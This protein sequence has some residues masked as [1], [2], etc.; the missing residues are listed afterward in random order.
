[1]TGCGT[2]TRTTLKR[3]SRAAAK[4]ASARLRDAGAV[5]TSP[6]VS[7]R[8]SVCQGCE[9]RKVYGGQAYCGKP[10]LRALDRR[11]E[12]GCGCPLAD[13]A[14]D[15]SEHCPLPVRQAGEAAGGQ[16]AGQVG[17]E[18]GVCDCRWCRETAYA[19]SNS[20]K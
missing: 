15:P 13:K 19:T 9:L 20:V 3:L 7:L 11:P 6:L 14:A 18:P 17:G 5:R 1:M 4:Y 16:S 10:L 8:L 12:E 2:C